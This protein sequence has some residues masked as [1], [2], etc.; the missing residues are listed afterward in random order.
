M[1]VI[2]RCHVGLD[3][4]NE[5]AREA[6]GF[7]EPY[8]LQADAY[9]FSRE[10][11]VWDELD[12]AR[13]RDHR[14]VDRR[15][16]AQERG[17][18]RPTAVDAMLAAAGLRAAARRA[19]V[20]QRAG[21]HAPARSRRR[22]TMLETRPLDA[23]ERYVLQVSRWDSLKDP[24]GVIEGFADARRAVHRRAPDLR[25]ARTSS[26]VADDPEGAEVYAVARA[27]WQRAA[28]RGARARPPRAA[29]DGRL[30]GERG[31]RQRAPARAP[32]SWCRRASP[33]A[34]A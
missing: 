8:V 23:G 29:A 3:V 1:P 11:F 12:P 28:G 2:W 19:P 22:A 27:R 10:A 24:I 15:L 16:R 33:R 20:F 7:L 25:R 17:A 30:R 26:A 31:D 5:L 4:P 32:T 6:W 21:R 13:A 9:V 34:S 14:A 18:R